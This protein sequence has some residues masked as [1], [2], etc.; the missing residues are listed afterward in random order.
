MLGGNN[1]LYNKIC[2]FRKIS[3]MAN[4][5]KESYNLLRTGLKPLNDGIGIR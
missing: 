5:V 4:Q 2:V 3:K 1:I